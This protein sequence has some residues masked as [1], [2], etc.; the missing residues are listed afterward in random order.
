MCTS[1]HTCLT[2]PIGRGSQFELEL[3]LLA[4]LMSLEKKFVRS[5]QIQ[6]FT[7]RTQLVA[8]AVVFSLLLLVHFALSSLSVASQLDLHITYAA[9]AAAAL[10]FEEEN[11]ARW[12]KYIIFLSSLLFLSFFLSFSFCFLAANSTRVGLQSEFVTHSAHRINHSP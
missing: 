12:Y 11:N 10:W 5:K 3:L 1:S 4:A 6:Y 7:A 8:F 2:N 9:A